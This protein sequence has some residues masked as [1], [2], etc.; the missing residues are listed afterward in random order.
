MTYSIYDCVEQKYLHFGL[1]LREAYDW[2]VAYDVNDTCCMYPDDGI[3]VSDDDDEDE[4][5]A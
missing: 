4:Y 3:Y 1:T 5:N 2:L